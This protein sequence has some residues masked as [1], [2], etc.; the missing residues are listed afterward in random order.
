MPRG[1][2]RHATRLLIMT[3]SLCRVAV[4]APHLRA[5]AGRQQ[6]LC[7]KD[8][9]PSSANVKEH[10]VFTCLFFHFFGTN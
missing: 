7:K 6:A 2:N 10:Q 1:T 5:M 3:V 8:Q 9:E 4:S